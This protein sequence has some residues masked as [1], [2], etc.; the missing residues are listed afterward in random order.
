MFGVTEPAGPS[1]NLYFSRG[2]LVRALSRLRRTPRGQCEY[3]PLYPPFVRGERK[4]VAPPQSS[5]L[6]KGGY[7]GVLRERASRVCNP[8]VKRSQLTPMDT[9]GVFALT[10]GC[11]TQS[12]PPPDGPKAPRGRHG[13]ELIGSVTRLPRVRP[14]RTC[15]RSFLVKVVAPGRGLVISGPGP[16]SRADD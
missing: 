15:R 14:A 5:P 11:A 16:G 6:T 12:L 4:R 13:A 3:T 1:K 10:P 9:G 2:L 7:R 8:T